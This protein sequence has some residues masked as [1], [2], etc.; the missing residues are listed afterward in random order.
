MAVAGDILLWSGVF[1]MGVTAIGLIRLPDFY[2]R[3]HA[4]SK[5]E[6]LGLGLVLLGLVLHAGIGQVGAKLVLTLLLASVVNPVAAHLLT[7]AAVRCGVPVWTHPRP[8]IPAA[9]ISLRRES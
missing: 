5:T 3:A 4:V 7:R 6:T 9:S 2:S 1:F 8:E